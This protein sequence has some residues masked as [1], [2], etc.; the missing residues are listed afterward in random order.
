MFNEVD[1]EP[2]PSSEIQTIGPST[3]GRCGEIMTAC[4]CTFRETMIWF[5]DIVHGAGT[6]EA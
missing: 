4:D 3:C 1:E 6:I 2:M 5:A